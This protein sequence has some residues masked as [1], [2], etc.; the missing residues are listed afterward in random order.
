[1][2]RVSGM[3]APAKVLTYIQEGLHSKN[4][5]CARVAV[6]GCVRLCV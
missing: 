2:V 1:M 6:C 3:Y 4:N 5:R